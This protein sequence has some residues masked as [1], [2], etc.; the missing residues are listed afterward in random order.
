MLAI[1][2]IF[3]ALALG[4][5]AQ[6]TC[7]SLANSKYCSS[8]KVSVSPVPSKFTNIDEFDQLVARNLENA[9][10]QLSSACNSR[11]Q[12]STIPYGVDGVCYLTIIGSGIFERV[13][14]TVYEFDNGLTCRGECVT[15]G[16]GNTAC[17]QVCV[18]STVNDN[19]VS[20]DNQDVCLSKEDLQANTL[21]ASSCSS[22]FSALSA[23][24]PAAVQ[25]KLDLCAGL[26][27]ANCVVGQSTVSA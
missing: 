16:A 5:F 22:L 14:N 27:T 12:L 19:S 6:N 20:T 25:I 3:A 8:F 2:T 18:S 15:D 26:P 17:S 13:N 24:C 9:S 21:C 1:L 10:V 4:A 7:I 23:Q 11:I